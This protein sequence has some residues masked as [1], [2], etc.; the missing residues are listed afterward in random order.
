M[1]RPIRGAAECLSKKVLNTRWVE[2]GLIDWNR[3][4]QERL[5]F[6]AVLLG[7]EAE[8]W[9]GSGAPGGWGVQEKMRGTETGKA[10]RN[11]PPLV[12]WISQFSTAYATNWTISRWAGWMGTI[13]ANDC[14]EGDYYC[15]S[16]RNGHLLQGQIQIWKISLFYLM[17]KT[18]GFH[19]FGS[20]LCTKG[21]T[22]E[23]G[24]TP[25]RLGG[26]HSRIRF[27]GNIIRDQVMEAAM[28]S[29]T[30]LGL[31]SHGLFVR[32]S[33]SMEKNKGK[34]TEPNITNLGRNDSQGAFH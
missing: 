6:A 22:A 13:C 20:G 23:L 17:G 26:S 33:I 19:G 12:Y 3:K 15:L 7:G 27:W 31:W 14:S 21:T 10:G 28:R 24:Q 9:K 25:R 8:A 2:G 5:T 18:W 34:T 4:C 11:S 30:V 1:C 32:T 16:K 29:P